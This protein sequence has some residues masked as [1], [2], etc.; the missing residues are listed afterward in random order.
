MNTSELPKFAKKTARKMRDSEGGELYLLG[1]L[2]T[3]CHQHQ[4]AISA[5]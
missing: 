3:A 1:L 4:L 5:G 2:L